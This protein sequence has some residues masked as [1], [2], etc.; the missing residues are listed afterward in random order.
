[1]MEEFPRVPQLM[2]SEP[3]PSRMEL[4]LPDSIL[5]PYSSLQTPQQMERK[6]S[7]N[8]TRQV[9][10]FA[11][12]RIAP[13]SQ[14]SS[15]ILNMPRSIQKLP[16]SSSGTWMLPQSAKSLATWQSAKE[17]LRFYTTTRWR[18][19]TS[20]RTCTLQRQVTRHTRSWSLSTPSSSH[21]TTVCSSTTSPWRSTKTRARTLKSSHT[22]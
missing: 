21:A 9:K 16:L 1:M 10:K 17:I 18:S 11:M 8:K 2:T 12:A 6:L 5:S 4:T 14:F 3:T 15:N 22:T 13:L 7:S 19:T 20:T